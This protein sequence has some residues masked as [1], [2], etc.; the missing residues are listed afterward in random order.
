MNYFV[1]LVV[2]TVPPEDE[3]IQ[4]NLPSLKHV[5]YKDPKMGFIDGCN[6]NKEQ[7]DQ[8]PCDAIN[9]DTGEITG[10]LSM[11]QGEKNSSNVTKSVLPRFRV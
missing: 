1:V 2:E 9:V 5:L 7:R 4:S 3:Q 8:Y 6:V 10:K 11:L